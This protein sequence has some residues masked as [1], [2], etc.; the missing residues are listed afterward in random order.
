MIVKVLLK[1]YYYS[2]VNIP[3]DC[4]IFTF[5]IVVVNRVHVNELL[6]NKHQNNPGK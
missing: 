1:N 4:F 5:W 2:N 6:V 3:Y